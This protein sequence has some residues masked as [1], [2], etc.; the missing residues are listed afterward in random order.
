MMYSDGGVTSCVMNL[1]RVSE[2][3]SGWTGSMTV[4]TTSVDLTSENRYSRRKSKTKT[5][6]GSPAKEVSMA[7][8]DCSE[9]GNEVSTK[10]DSCPTCGNRIRH[11]NRDSCMGCILIAFT[12]FVVWMVVTYSMSAI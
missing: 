8:T 6:G 7:M 12:I 2:V 4:W 3:M 10:A 9:C 11:R 5:V 1:L